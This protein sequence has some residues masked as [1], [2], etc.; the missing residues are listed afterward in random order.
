MVMSMFAE[1]GQSDVLEVSNECVHRSLL[2]DE[3]GIVAEA[4]ILPE[5]ESE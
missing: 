3:A 1:D 4:H 5:V 2:Q